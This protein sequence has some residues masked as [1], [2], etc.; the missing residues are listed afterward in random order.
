MKCPI[1]FRKELTLKPEGD[2]INTSS[3]NCS[4]VNCFTLISLVML[5]FHKYIFSATCLCCQIPQ[6]LPNNRRC[7]LEPRVSSGLHSF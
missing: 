7:L 3:V 6:L 5:L 1:H 4:I 2:D